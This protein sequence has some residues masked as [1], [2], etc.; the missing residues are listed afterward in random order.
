[1]SR[2]L[3]V[4]LG[5]SSLTFL[6]ACGREGNLA[7]LPAANSTPAAQP[8][9]LPV[10]APKPVVAEKP[11]SDDKPA[12]EAIPA[13]PPGSSF[14]SGQTEA[15]RRST[16][17]PKVSS[18]VTRVLVRDGDIVKNGQALVVLDTQDFALRTQQAE[19]ALQAAKV[20]L[21]SAKLD[22]NRAKALLDDKAVPQ[23]QFDMADARLKG[24][25]AGVLQAETAVAMGRKAFRDATIHAPFNGL[26]V[27]RLVNEGEYASV[28][29][30]TPLVIVEEV[31]PLDLRIQIPS[32]DLN[33]AKAGDMV[34]VR[35]PA[36]GQTLEAR[37]T[38]VVAAMDPRTRTFSAIAE[39]PNKDHALRSGLYA[40]VSFAASTPA[41]VEAPAGKAKP[42][43]KTGA[44][45]GAKAVPAKKVTAA[46]KD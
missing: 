25:Q 45:S 28:M 46:S 44:K 11:V 3:L 12:S 43:A 42:A 23:A 35:F 16:L 6:A 33:K 5:L 24:A 18:T 9:P 26:I 1:M 21:D 4:S 36:T 20:Q 2:N 19:A 32:T 41:S 27:K 15:H 30:A 38:R 17:T 22:W 34:K 10:P 7:S 13:P 14:L 29:P 31:D 37:L 39:L 8:A 40:E